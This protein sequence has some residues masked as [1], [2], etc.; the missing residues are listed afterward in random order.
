VDEAVIAILVIEH[1]EGSAA[2]GSF[3]QTEPLAN[4]LG[5]LDIPEEALVSFCLLATDCPKTFS[6]ARSSE[7]WPEWLKAILEEIAKLQRYNVYQIVERTGDM[8]VLRAR[9]V[10][11][12]KMDPETGEAAAYKARWV[13]KGYTQIEGLDFQEIFASVAHKDTLRV[14]LAIVNWLKLHCD[15]VDI[16][17]AFLNG[18]L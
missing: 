7:D 8:R 5:L 1:P 9:W 6:Q 2:G 10:F 15:Q 14:F 18:V 3:K 16:I 4:L 17:A 11:T 13:A 12:R